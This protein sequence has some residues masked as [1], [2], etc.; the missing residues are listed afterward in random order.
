[1]TFFLPSEPQ[2]RP[3]NPAPRPRA[4]FGETAAAAWTGAAISQNSWDRRG[5]RE[6]ELLDEVN[7]QLARMKAPSPMTRDAHVEWERRPGGLAALRKQVLEAAANA[8]AEDPGRWGSL[9]I[10][11]EAFQA[12]IDRELKAELDDANE[13]LSMGGR[14]AGV[15]EFLGAAGSAAT[16]PLS[17]AMLP[18]GGTGG[19]MRILAT[20]AALGAAGEAL[21]LPAQYR[22][23]EALEQ[24]DPDALTQIGI[25]AAGGAILGAGPVAAVRGTGWAMRQ[26]GREAGDASRPAAAGPVEHEVA[27]DQ[28]TVAL[29]EGRPVPPP[30]PVSSP[31]DYDRLSRRIVGVESGGRAN[32][33][34]PGSSATGAGQFIDA[35]WLDMIARHRP[36]LAATRGRADILA[37]RSDPALSREM[38]AA[39]ALDNAAHLAAQGLEATEP[40]LYL[41]HFLGPGG[42]TRALLA[43]PDAPVTSVMTAAQIDAN[44]NVTF[45]GRPLQHWSVKDLRRWSEFKM[46]QA[47]DPG[48]AYQ[49][50]TR[51]GYTAGDEVATP[52]GT[53]VQ[54]EYEVVDMDTLTLASG[55]RQPRDRSRLAPTAKVKERAAALDPALLMPSPLAS[56]GAPVVGAD[57]VIDSGNGRVMSLMHAAD[58]FPDR[59]AAYVETIRASFDVPEGMARP[60]LIARRRTDLDPDELR[61]FVR[62][63][64]EDSVERMSP[65]EQSRS[66]AEAL[67]PD[68]LARFDPEAGGIA[69]PGNRDFLR[70]LVGALPSG[71]RGELLTDKG[72]LSTAGHTRLQAALFARGYDAPDLVAAMTEEGGRDVKAAIDAMTDAAPAWAQLRADAAEGRLRP[73]YDLTDALTGAVRLVGQAREKARTEGMT[74]RGALDDMMAQDDMLGGGADPLTARMV[75]V[76]YR[77]ARARSREDIARGLRAYVDEAGR[78][79]AEGGGLL[80]QIA[81]VG[82]LDVIDAVTRRLDDA[83]AP[84]GAPG[85]AERIAS[86]EPALIDLAGADDAAWR[87]GAASPAARAADDQSAAELR[88][89]TATPRTEDPATATDTDA[90]ELREAGRLREV[91]QRTDA[92]SA[93]QPFVTID[94]LYQLAPDAQ[95]QLARIGERLSGEL[96]VK[97]KNP[98]IKR[99]ETTEEKLGRKGYRRITQLTDIARGGFVVETAVQA[100]GIIDAF[101]AAG[102]DFVDEGWTRKLATGFVDRKVLLRLD[103]GLLAEIQIWSAPMIEA[104]STRGQALYTKAR[105]STD[106]DEI[107]R[108]NQE[109]L[110]VYNDA[111]ARSDPALQSLF[112]SSNEPNSGSNI[113]R[114]KASSRI[115][116]AV[117]PT[118]S[119]ST[120]DQSSPGASSANALSPTSTAGRQSQFP[121]RMEDPSS[122]WDIPNIGAPAGQV[123][124]AAAGDFT[125]TI[126]GVDMRAS[127]VLRDL[128]ADQD[129]AEQVA[130]CRPGGSRDG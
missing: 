23:A 49:S 82:P 70:A 44:R 39:Y 87:D 65:S 9:P 13:T 117:A 78:V 11:E 101:R 41:A 102:L 30:P 1:M 74:V 100:D 22:T 2:A 67:T 97:F 69:A 48:A 105:S 124:D 25:G 64:N 63:A 60:V 93:A 61:R 26:F 17:L 114:N 86:D 73:E 8:A 18:L 95:A 96:G 85:Q 111:L 46:G 45:A 77:G 119:R 94:E 34:N 89:A 42:A 54:V 127:D 68:V 83:P 52:A 108:L 28:A 20:E 125:V 43:D 122:G 38:T 66:D 51:R 15:A 55:D 106:P 110:D 113:A 92:L 4:G 47:A 27:T 57:D 21:A 16:D 40:N 32:A 129:F 115:S 130:F 84:E 72:G 109:Q 112:G 14:G 103:N 58:Q 53:R 121:N 37:L 128:D 50:A 24:P 79:G 126:D 76:L 91:K 12:Q 59:Y 120:S 104:K 88:Q 90:P 33:K 7:A 123:N 36:D 35:T 118:S 6:R 80:D 29:R 62:E 116:D 99:R 107:A 10:S 56:H 5:Q 31:Q 98:G 19:L 81:P 75:G 3:F 71:Q